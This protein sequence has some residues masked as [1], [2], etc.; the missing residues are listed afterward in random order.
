MADE[1][2][3]SHLVQKRENILSVI[4]YYQGED[5]SIYRLGPAGVIFAVFQGK[6]PVLFSNSDTLCRP[7]HTYESGGME[8]FR[9]SFLILFIMML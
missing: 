4:G 1:I 7:S 6:T 3:I 5:S 2:D 8:S 9:P